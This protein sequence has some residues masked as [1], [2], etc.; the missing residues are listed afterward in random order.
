MHNSFGTSY[1]EETKDTIMRCGAKWCNEVVRVE[2]QVSVKQTEGNVNSQVRCICNDR[3][4]RNP[5]IR[6]LNIRPIFSQHAQGSATSTNNVHKFE[7]YLRTFVKLSH[8]SEQSM[9]PSP[10]A[11]HPSPYSNPE[12]SSHDGRIRYTLTSLNHPR[13]CQTRHPHRPPFQRP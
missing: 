13:H 5:Y 10:S 1:I 8:Q 3:C 12:F 7:G 9:A 11:I 6:R 2:G 4:N